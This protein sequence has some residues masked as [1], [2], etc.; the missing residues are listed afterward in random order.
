MFTHYW[1]I[2]QDIT[3]L[4]KADRAEILVLKSSGYICLININSSS[5]NRTMLCGRVCNI[6]N[7]RFLPLYLIDD[8]DFSISLVPFLMVQ[9]KCSGSSGVSGYT[10][11]SCNCKFVATKIRLKIIVISH[12]PDFKTNTSSLTFAYLQVQFPS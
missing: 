12:F 6:K 7:R 9:F 1:F 8:W 10:Y 4:S 2:V 3:S 11:H 5:S